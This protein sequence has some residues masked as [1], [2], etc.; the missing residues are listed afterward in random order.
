MR[1]VNANGLPSL[2]LCSVSR[3]SAGST[4]PAWVYMKTMFLTTTSATTA[5]RLQVRL[6]TTFMHRFLYCQKDGSH[7][8]WI[9]R[10]SC[11]FLKRLLIEGPEVV[12]RLSFIPLACRLEAGSAFPLWNWLADLRSYVWPLMCK[13]ELRPD[14]RLQDFPHP[15][16]AGAHV[17]DQSGP[18]WAAAE[19]QPATVSAAPSEPSLWVCTDA[20]LGCLSAQLPVP[21]RPAAVEVAVETGRGGTTHVQPRRSTS[22]VLRQQRA[23]LPETWSIMGKSRRAEWGK[24]NNISQGGGWHWREGRAETTTLPRTSIWILDVTMSL[25]KMNL[26]MAR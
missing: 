9:N 2:W 4:A 17:S 26:K 6:V 16:S 15:P 23:L 14:Q 19:D 11:V 5:G 7:F 3:V 25:L 21:G 13:G 22:C 1:K 18:Q 10:R 8:L 12:W 24:T 20:R